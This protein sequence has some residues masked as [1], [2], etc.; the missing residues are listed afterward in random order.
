[1]CRDSM[2]REQTYIPI[3]IHMYIQTHRCRW[4]LSCLVC[5]CECARMHACMHACTHTYIH[6]YVHTCIYTCCW[7]LSCSALR[8]A[9]STLSLITTAVVNDS[10]SC[11]LCFVRVAFRVSCMNV[12]V[13]VCVRA[14]V[15]YIHKHT[16]NTN[17]HID[18][19][20]TCVSH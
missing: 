8:S 9:S 4:C 14:R 19:L 12:R 18:A 5:I 3:Y 7:S 17:T 20:Y 2:V 1:V 16:Y 10:S 15:Y 13:C 11:V 6:T